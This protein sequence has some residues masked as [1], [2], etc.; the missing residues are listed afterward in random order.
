MLRLHRLS[1]RG[2]LVIG[3]HMSETGLQK[4]AFFVL[5]LLIL[6]V[7]IAGGV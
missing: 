5:L 4:L 7:A 1:L 6:F 2:K 3:D